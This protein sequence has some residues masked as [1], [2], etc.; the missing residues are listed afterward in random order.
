MEHSRKKSVSF[1]ILVCCLTLIGSTI[2][3]AILWQPSFQYGFISIPYGKGAMNFSLL[4]FVPTLICIGLFLFF[5]LKIY[6]YQNF[7][8]YFKKAVFFGIISISLLTLLFYNLSYGET[9]NNR[10]SVE[11]YSFMYLAWPFF[12]L[13][14]LHAAVLL[15]LFVKRKNTLKGLHETSITKNETFPFIPSAGNKGF[16]KVGVGDKPSAFVILL[17]FGTLAVLNT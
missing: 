17:N 14:I 15:F 8:R 6:K 2:L 16:G 10:S 5:L 3:F 13:I 9:G 4:L 11:V 12:T 1:Y 7:Y